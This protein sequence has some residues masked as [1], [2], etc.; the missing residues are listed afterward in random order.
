MS[1]LICV[2][3]ALF[4]LSLL[5]DVEMLPLVLDLEFLGVD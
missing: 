1:V 3:D 4:M 2:Q 5:I